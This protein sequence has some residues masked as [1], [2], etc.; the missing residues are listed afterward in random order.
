MYPTIIAL[1]HYSLVVPDTI[2]LRDCITIL[3]LQQKN[4][5][6]LKRYIRLVYAGNMKRYG[7][8]LLRLPGLRTVAMNIQ[9]VFEEFI[10]ADRMPVNEMVESALLDVVDDIQTIDQMVITT[11]PDIPAD[12]VHMTATDDTNEKT[13]S[14]TEK[15]E[16]IITENVPIESA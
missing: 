14:P 15:T 5:T 12:D 10:V 6:I 2:G 1:L 13:E 3:K 8:I 16:T 9:E 4:L 11:V 7:R